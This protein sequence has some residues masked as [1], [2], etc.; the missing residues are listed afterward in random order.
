MI[1]IKTHTTNSTFNNIADL[2]LELAFLVVLTSVACI[3]QLVHE[4][5]MY[6]AMQQ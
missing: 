5:K 4:R 2:E 6:L 3:H 1:I